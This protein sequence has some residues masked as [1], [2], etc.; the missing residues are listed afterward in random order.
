EA[1]GIHLRA[2]DGK[3][4]MDIPVHWA[5]GAGDQAVTFVTRVNEEWYLE[6][7][8][9]YYSAL[10]SF[11]PTPGQEALSAATLPQ[12][13]GTLYKVLDPDVGIRGCF[14][15]HSTGPVSVTPA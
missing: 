3:D 1:G 7:Y 10:R 12:A 14:E 13:M 8:L 15:C 5:F 2:S 4:V 11:A 9:T 6:H